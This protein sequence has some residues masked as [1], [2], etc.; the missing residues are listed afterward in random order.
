LRPGK[1]VVERK[2][3]LHAG[4]PGDT[5]VKGVLVLTL[6]LVCQGA[7]VIVRRGDGKGHWLEGMLLQCLCEFSSLRKSNLGKLTR[8][9]SSLCVRG[10][11]PRTT[12]LP[13]SSRTAF[14]SRTIRTTDRAPKAQRQNLRSSDDSRREDWN[15]F[16]EWSKTHCLSSNRPYQSQHKIY[17][18]TF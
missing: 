11:I 17:C 8:A 9:G 3:G 10:T 7:S 12:A 14:P 4:P 18:A 6:L 16:K 13:Q 5:A 15:L 1:G 2:R